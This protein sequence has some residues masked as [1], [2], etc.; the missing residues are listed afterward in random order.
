VYTDR[1]F[2]TKQIDGIG[3][4]SSSQPGIMA[5]MLEQLA[6]EP[7]QRVQEIGAGTGYNAALL[8]ELAGLGGH[9]TTVDIDAD[10]AAGAEE[11]LRLAGYDCVQVV[12]GDGGL[13]FPDNA[14]YDRIIAT[15]SCWQIPQPW[16]DQLV[17]GGVL[18]VPFRLNG[19]HAAL[20]FRKRGDALISER[21]CECGF[22]P[23]RGAFGK[24]HADMV[25]PNVGVW[26]DCDVDRTMKQSVT[27]LLPQEREVRVRFPRG[28]DR[29]NGPLYYLS[30]Q[31]RVVLQP[32]RRPIGSESTFLLLVSPE[33]AIGLR[34]NG[35]RR[36]KVTLLGTDEALDFLADALRRWR[37]EG[38]PDVRDLRMAVRRASDE[39]IG[40]LPEPAGD[41]YAMRR[42]DH[43]YEVWF[44]R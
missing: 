44:E 39:A 2:V 4:S 17:E 19:V 7:G 1:A 20:A 29:R 37:A 41:R 23:L 34:W 22:M 21:A 6:L 30:L 18:V 36:G 3:V 43:D 40:P 16:I 12:T 32:I 10:T 11:H 31:G 38:Q 5:V 27:D 26:A 13:G 42:G 28:R 33:S 9:V 24:L 35:P 15:A 14:P 25:A 8:S